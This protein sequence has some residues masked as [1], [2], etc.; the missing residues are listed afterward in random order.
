MRIA[1]ATLALLSATAVF[2]KGQD[3]ILVNLNMMENDSMDTVIE[4]LKDDVTEKVAYEK[5]EQAK[6]NRYQEIDNQLTQIQNFT[7]V[8]CDT[9]SCASMK[10]ELI[11]KLI[12]MIREENREFKTVTEY[13]ENL[14]EYYFGTQNNET[15]TE[16]AIKAYVE[17][18]KK[19]KIENID[20]L[21]DRLEYL[22]DYDC[23]GNPNCNTIKEAAM[24]DIIERIMEINNM[25][26]P[27]TTYIEDKVEEKIEEEKE[28]MEEEEEMDKFFNDMWNDVMNM[29]DTTVDDKVTSEI[30][31]G[32]EID[33]EFLKIF[34]LEEYINWDDEEQNTVEEDKTKTQVDEN[35]KDIG[36]QQKKI[37]VLEEQ[38]KENTEN[39]AINRL[40]LTNAKYD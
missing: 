4:K 3:D 8:D 40:M 27:T 14:E 18:L 33:Q 20:D 2:G 28:E 16:E 37:D 30:G 9:R 1:T 22:N 34:G 32:D 23:M 24:N 19:D 26:I 17:S 13:K 31:Y 21:V 6:R 7:T 29:F 12:E 25:K 5:L 15:L 11:A 39:A 36:E 10:K 38:V 35:T